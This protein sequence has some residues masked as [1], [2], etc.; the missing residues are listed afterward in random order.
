MGEYDADTGKVYVNNH[1]HMVVDYH[2]MEISEVR[3]R[4]FIV[5]LY[6]LNVTL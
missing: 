5:Y 3:C 2:P 6:I 4:P 1:V